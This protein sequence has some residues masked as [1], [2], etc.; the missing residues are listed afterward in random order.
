MIQR[1]GNIRTPLRR[2]KKRDFASGFGDELT[3][4]KVRQVLLTEGAGPHGSGELP[5]RTGFGS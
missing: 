1:F 2:D 3:E 4:S 5:W